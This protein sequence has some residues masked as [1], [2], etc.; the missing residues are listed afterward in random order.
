M[1]GF[2]THAGPHRRHENAGGGQKR[3]VA[4]QLAVDHGGER[5]EFR[6]HREEGFKHAINGEECVGQGHPADDGAEH[7]ALVPLLAG[8]VGG[9]GEVA[10][11]DH[12]QPTHALTA[13]GIH[14]VRHGGRPHLPFLEALGDGL[15]AGHEPNGVGERRRP[16]T[17]LHQGGDGVEVEGAGID[18]AHGVKDPGEAEMGGDAEFQF[19]KF[20]LIPTH[21]VE[22]VLGSAHGALDAPQRVAFDQV[23][24]A[25]DGDQKFLSGGGEPFP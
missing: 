12:L 25:F 21:E 8:Q 10:A 13:A 16:R 1:S 6:Q 17:K 4:F 14:F 15:I 7:V 18:L 11:Q 2:P 20:R 24:D 22:H 19:G 5:P 9:H 23:F 3:Q